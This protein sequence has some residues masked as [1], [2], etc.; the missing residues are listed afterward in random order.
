MVGAVLNQLWPDTANVATL[1]S[2]PWDSRPV[3]YGAVTSM[4]LAFFLIPFL[5]AKQ[6]FGI[7]AGR[8]GGVVVLA[9]CLKFFIA[10]FPGAFTF[11][12]TGAG[13]G[14]VL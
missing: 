6:T 12:A 2:L 4:F 8:A 10:F 9:A 1:R 7:T 11:V 3:F 14:A 13:T 5:M